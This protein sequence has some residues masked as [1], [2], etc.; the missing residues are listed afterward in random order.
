MLQQAA[1][2]VVEDFTQVTVESL[3]QMFLSARATKTV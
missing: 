1:D 2:W 3:K